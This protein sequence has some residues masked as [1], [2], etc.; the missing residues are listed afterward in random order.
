[1]QNTITEAISIDE[2]EGEPSK[3][4]GQSE[5]CLVMDANMKSEQQKDEAPGWGSGYDS[6]S[7]LP[8]EFLHYFY[9]SSN[10]MGTLIEVSSPNIGAKPFYV[11]LVRRTWDAYIRPGG[12]Y[13]P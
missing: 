13:I 10:D 4:K 5:R 6:V 3:T 11:I 12:R 8:F 1:M 7:N 2:I 9:G